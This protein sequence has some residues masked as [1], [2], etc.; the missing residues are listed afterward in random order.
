MAKRGPKPKVKETKGTLAK[1]KREGN[2][3]VKFMT[4]LESVDRTA[5]VGADP[6]KHY[7]YCKTGNVGLRESQ[8]YNL[9]D[10][11]KI[12][13]KNPSGSLT[14]GAEG[15]EAK[16]KG[17]DL[18]LMEM[19]N[20]LYEQRQAV[21]AERRRELNEGLDKR[22]GQSEDSDPEDVHMLKRNDSFRKEMQGGR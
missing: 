18:V 2:P 3:N 11:T 20:E 21:K 5:L 12:K 19:P 9:S 17:H 6:N 1:L 16:L 10:D 15:K 22:M 7:R 13:V 14:W 4:D 8:G